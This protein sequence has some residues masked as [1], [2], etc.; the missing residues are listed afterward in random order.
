LIRGKF[1]TDLPIFSYRS[2]L[3]RTTLFPSFFYTLVAVLARSRDETSTRR[4]LDATPLLSLQPN[5]TAF[6]HQRIH[7]F[8]PLRG[9]ADLGEPIISAS[10]PS[11]H[12]HRSSVLA[13][14]QTPSDVARI[15]TGA[16][17]SA[18][19]AASSSLITVSTVTETVPSKRTRDILPDRSS[20]SLPSLVQ[21]FDRRISACRAQRAIL[22]SLNFLTLP[23][24][25][26]ASTPSTRQTAFESL[27]ACS[28]SSFS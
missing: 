3:S 7:D 26:S 18:H 16:F 22:S 15:T 4:D 25:V 13:G 20:A 12:V 8:R 9:L 5:S 11:R 21:P 14:S 23:C 6:H 27:L 28:C 17:K 10:P 1:T 2:L 19:C 24:T